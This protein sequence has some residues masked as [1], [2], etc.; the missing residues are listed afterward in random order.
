MRVFILPGLLFFGV[1]NHG[2]C[3]SN[4]NHYL[5]RAN[6]ALQSQ[7]RIH[8]STPTADGGLLVV[9][10]K[11]YNDDL[12]LVGI[13]LVKFDN[14]GNSVWTKMLSGIDSPVRTTRV[15]ELTDGSFVLAGTVN[16]SVQGFVLKTTALGD[17]L[18]MKLMQHILRTFYWSCNKLWKKHYI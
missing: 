7:A 10:D 15:L 4:L 12:S 9:T 5:I 17:F 11:E 6:S 14:L 18:F 2:I 16:S 8:A 3:Q 1:I 13:S